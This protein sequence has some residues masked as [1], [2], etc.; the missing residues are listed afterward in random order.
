MDISLDDGDRKTLL[1]I[2]KARTIVGIF[3]SYTK[4]DELTRIKNHLNH[5]VGFLSYLADDLKQIYPKREIQTVNS[6][7]RVLSE[8][9]VGMSNIH[10]FIFFDNL[11]GES[12]INQSVVSEIR[13][14]Y[15]ITKPCHKFLAECV[16][17]YAQKGVNIRSLLEDL[18]EERTPD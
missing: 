8:K 17:I 5:N 13:Y 2:R 1:K 14:L 4:F 18:I 15:D 12:E 16:V 11:P 9:L 3:G 6:Y 10:L 7:N